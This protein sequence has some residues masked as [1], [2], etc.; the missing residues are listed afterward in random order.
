MSAE[1]EVLIARNE[2][3]LKIPVAAVVETDAGN[4]C[5]VKTARGAE[6]RVLELGDS[7]DVF[8]VVEKGLQEGDEVVLNPHAYGEPLSTKTLHEKRPRESD[9]TEAGIE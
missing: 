7:N 3:V 5:W 6:R 1:V 8:T 2:D 4:F 9:S